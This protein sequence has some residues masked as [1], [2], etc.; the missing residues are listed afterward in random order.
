M[1]GSAHPPKA[2]FALNVAVV[3]HRPNRLPEHGRDAMTRRVGEA[4]EQL[5][6]AARD[7]FT[8]HAELYAATPAVVRLVSPLAE[9]ADRIAAEAALD[10]GYSLCYVLPF[11]P[12]EY[13][14]DFA[15]Q[16]S[17]AHF[18]SLLERGEA[19]VLHQTREDEGRAYELAGRA[20][21]DA[22]DIVLA[23]W[24]RRASGGRGGT[25]EL[26]SYAAKAGL[27]I[28]HVDAEGAA[29]T[30]VLWDGLARVPVEAADVADLP[31]APLEDIAA[32]VERSI[33]P[34]QGATEAA[35]LK[36]FLAERHAPRNLRI[37]VPV[38]LALLGLR[39][40]RKTDLLPEPPNRLAERFAAA[41]GDDERRIA[42]VA[43]AYG[44]ADALGNRYAQTFRSAYSLNFLLA[45]LAVA[46]AVLPLV[47]GALLDWPKLPFVLVEIV[48]IVGIIVNTLHGRRNDYH[49]RWLESREVA[50]RLR[51]GLLPWLLGRRA[52]A[53]TSARATWTGW[54][55]RAH[56]RALGPRAGDLDDARVAELGTTI[57]S[58]IDDQCRYHTAT[59]ERM[60]RTERRLERLGEA[61]FVLTLVVAVAYVAATLAGRHP[62]T[63][64]SYAVT[65]LTA[66]LP[67]F[68]SALFGVRLIGDFHGTAERSTRAGA[69]LE[70]IGRDVRDT[71]SL[72]ALS[73]LAQAAA[74]AMLGD[75]AHWRLSRETRPLEL[76][77]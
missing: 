48:L 13:A 46:M 74:T 43:A 19:L 22:A 1:T 36:A 40:M 47:A 45:A 31:S 10:Q 14:K 65:A 51:A 23:V 17:R 12:D 21:I 18:T 44:W 50:E 49:G 59:G 64:W 70:A 37:E 24:D 42:P 28:V 72:P 16:R 25:R 39:P 32:V 68:G 33:G 3:G 2:R 30:R 27:P 75:V 56:F 6:A 9:G 61:F 71:H 20:A 8:R 76:P 4:L 58:V 53:E 11:S 7:A 29:P 5:A 66:G 52:R 62:S 38:L 57:A 54:Y 55:A 26:L 35:R 34:P 63:I 69:A 60:H 67:A 73:L 41:I 77:G 15:E